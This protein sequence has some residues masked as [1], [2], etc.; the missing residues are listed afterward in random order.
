MSD[1]DPGGDP[2]DDR[3][4]VPSPGG[5]T[6]VVDDEA[7][8]DLEPGRQTASGRGDD[9]TPDGDDL[10]AIIDYYRDRPVELY[11][12]VGYTLADTQIRILEAC[13]DHDRVLVWSGNGTGKTAGVMMAIYWFI[14]TRYN[15]LGLVT[16]G[17]YPVL[18]DTSAPFL[19]SI[20][21]RVSAEFPAI[22]SAATWKNSPPQID[23]DDVPEWFLRFRSPRKPKNLEGR[24]A[25]RAFVVV[26]EADKDDVTAEHFSA[27]TSTASNDQD[28]VVAIANPPESRS[29]VVYEKWRSDRWHTIEF[30]SFDSHNVKRRTGRLDDD[31]GSIPGL[32][33]LSLIKEDYEAWNGYDWPG[34]DAVQRAV[35]VN[36][37]GRRVARASHDRNLD[38]RWFRKRLGVM[39]P[40]G[41]G[42]LR[43]FYLKDVEAAIERY[44]A[45]VKADRLPI[46]TTRKT[47]RQVGVDIARDGGDRTVAI[48]R[49][50]D[51]DVLEPLVDQR[52]GDHE[53]N[54][55]LISDADARIDR[56]GPLVVDAVGEGSGVADRLR[57]THTNV[58]R[59]D[60]GENADDEDEYYNRQTE[61]YVALGNWIKAGGMI[62]PNTDLAK[63]IRAASRVLSLTERSLRGGTTLKANGKDTLKQ[64]S[65]LGRSPD[66]LDAAALAAYDVYR[67]DFTD[68]SVSGIVG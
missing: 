7:K 54:Y 16:S 27:A 26:D 55:D 43:P 68:P 57:A 29:N 42:T 53:R 44:R 11:E 24:H 6:D 33:D 35:E 31:R 46:R 32:V 38:P 19:E 39:P 64:E 18:N 8:A 60:A 28:V 47:A 52:P 10:M 13:Q 66:V 4:P 50:S 1:A 56:S 37:Q 62:P 21:K 3:P 63:E 40:A 67:S 9:W 15:S 61:A 2:D 58:R 65:H 41:S 20:H 17:N 12:D 45:A 5:L 34:V 49:W 48:G 22:D 23:F 25:R 14:I 36:D 30:S 59:F 51:P